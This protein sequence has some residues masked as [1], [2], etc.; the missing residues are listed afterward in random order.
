MAD[1]SEKDSQTPFAET[2]DGGKAEVPRSVKIRSI[3]GDKSREASL[4]K[5]SGGKRV[6]INQASFSDRD[7]ITYQEPEFFLFLLATEARYMRRRFG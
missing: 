4:E 1:G 7:E 3:R 2:F 5:I 6:A